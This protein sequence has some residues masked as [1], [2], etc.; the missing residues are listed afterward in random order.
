VGE[1]LSRVVASLETTPT[2]GRDERERRRAGWRERLGN[3]VRSFGGQRAEPVLL[4]RPDKPANA[5]V[6]G[7]RGAGGDEREAAAGALAA[8][9]HRPRGRSTAAVAERRAESR[10]GVA[11]SPAQLLSCSVADDAVHG[12]D[13]I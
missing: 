4:P 3:G 1:P 8:P 13:Q 7:D 9:R 11:T 12:Q 6:V 5:L 2:I 10:E